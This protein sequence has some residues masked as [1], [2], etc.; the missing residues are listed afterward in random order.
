MKLYYSDFNLR[1]T[2]TNVK[3]NNG[4]DK[5]LDLSKGF[6]LINYHL[7]ITM[8]SDYDSNGGISL[9]ISG[10]NPQ[11]YDNN[12]KSNKPIAFKTNIYIVEHDGQLS[13]VTY[14]SGIEF[15]TGGSLYRYIII[16][17]LFDN[18]P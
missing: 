14:G 16:Y 13:I 10:L 15:N 18:L 12:P 1:C 2:K 6:Y 11:Y 3:F 9:K 5:Y 17:K 4:N 8:S 7:P